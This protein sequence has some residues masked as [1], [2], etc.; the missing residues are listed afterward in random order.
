M[1]VK[2][3]DL[4]LFL[5]FLALFKIY[6]IP[7]FIQQITKI[8][9]IFTVMIYV[10]HRQKL[11]VLFNST[12]FF[13]LI[14]ML[15]SVYNAFITGSIEV[16]GALNGILHGCCIYICFMLVSYCAKD[17]MLN[18]VINILF[19]VLSIYA[20]LSLITAFING[21]SEEEAIYYFAGNKFR[22]SYYFMLLWSVI[23]VKFYEKFKVNVVLFVLYRF[24]FVFLIMFC[25]WIKCS[26][27]VVGSIVMLLMTF[28]SERVRKKLLSW[29]VIIVSI[30]VVGLIILL[31]RQIV[32][33][34]Y[35][36]YF[37][38]NILGEN[39]GF[40]GRFVIYDRLFDIVK[41]HP[42][43][44]FGYGN[45]AI[46]A[47]VASYFSNAQNSVIQGVI[48]YGL[49]GAVAFGLMIR[50]LFV[51]KTNV[52][53]GTDDI[54]RIWGMY[55]FVF[56]MIICSIVEITFNYMFYTA[57]FFVGAYITQ[58]VNVGDEE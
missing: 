50:Q 54:N 8:V 14:I 58:I 53:I 48:D 11:N 18:H 15:S 31:L 2:K 12:L 37:I 52:E 36:E 39:L 55:M 19:L 5:C 34:E 45:S 57:L 24:S 47:Y 29:K 43:F 41:I 6:A 1:K 26:T 33:I 23:Y 9:I 38:V 51:I 28:F 16:S 27:A 49:F 56:S 30:V 7:T 25:Y 3:I 32:D 20:I 4:V 42:F 40:T 35:I 21:T 46:Q 44:G 17:N 22:T 10:V 13:C